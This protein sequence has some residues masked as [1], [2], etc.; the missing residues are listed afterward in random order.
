MFL[1]NY[2]VHESIFEF[3]KDSSKWW[4]WGIRISGN[5]VVTGED[6]SVTSD[7]IGVTIQLLKQITTISYSNDAVPVR[8][9]GGK[10]LGAW[11][12][13]E[14]AISLYYI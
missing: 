6:E 9:R 3:L 4:G 7:P 5:S 8:S 2:F 10:T 13:D 14:T 1:K 11:N 12:N